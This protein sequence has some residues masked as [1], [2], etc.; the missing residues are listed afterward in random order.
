VQAEIDAYSGFQGTSLLELLRE[1]R[2]TRVFIGGIATEYCVKATVIDAL[3]LGFSTVLLTDAIR[4]I[5]A[6]SADQEKAVGQ[7]LEGGA[8]ALTID[9][10]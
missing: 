10:F 9:D 8:V 6:N 7:M 3:N 2:I 4:G 5:D 1:K